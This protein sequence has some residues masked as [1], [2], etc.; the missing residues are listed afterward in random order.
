MTDTPLTRGVRALML[1]QSGVDDFEV[2]DVAMQEGLLDGVR[3]VLAANRKPDDAMI[4]TGKAALLQSHGR[5][6]D[7]DLI[8][9]WERMIDAAI[10]QG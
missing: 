5:S 9:I 6:T 8:V 4:A 3:A 1:S 7:I 10:S 2:L